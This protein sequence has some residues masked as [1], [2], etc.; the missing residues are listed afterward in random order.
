MVAVFEPGAVISPSHDDSP[1]AV[2]AL[3]EVPLVLTEVQF[4]GHSSSYHPVRP[5]RGLGPVR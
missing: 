4:L 5:H 1:L 2:D 3:A